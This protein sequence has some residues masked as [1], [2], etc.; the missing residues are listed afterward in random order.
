MSIPNVDFHHR[1]LGAVGSAVLAFVLV[2]NL[3]F[4]Y[5]GFVAHM[6]TIL[7]PARLEPRYDRTFI[8]HVLMGR[9]AAWQLGRSMGWPAFALCFG[10]VVL[11]FRSARNRTQW[12]LLPAV[13]YYLSF[14]SV[15]M[16]HYDRFFLGIAV[17]LGVYGGGALARL[18][19]EGHGVRWRRLTCVLVLGYG[20]AYGAAPGGR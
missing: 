11:A 4:N 13:S 1:L 15:I 10:G 8:G 17:I 2:F 6:Q 20:L 19:G 5:D 9:D 14:I 12:F 18:A 16:Y 3:A 7:G